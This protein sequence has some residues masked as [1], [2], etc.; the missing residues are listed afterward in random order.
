MADGA[1]FKGIREWFQY[2]GLLRSFMAETI[3]IERNN[4][5]FEFILNG[6]LKDNFIHPNALYYWMIEL[7]KV[8]NWDEPFDLDLSLGGVK[9]SFPCKGIERLSRELVKCHDGIYRN[10][11]KVKIQVIC[12]S[13]NYNVDFYVDK[14]LQHAGT[15]GSDFGNT[16]KR[17]E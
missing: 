16:I 7:P 13:K 11:A 5:G 12:N 3:Y 14:K 4:I 15:I 1:V 2:Y 9:P 6:T 8:L 10:C 17:N